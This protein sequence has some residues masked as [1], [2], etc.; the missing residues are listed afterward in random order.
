M[1]PLLVGT[2]TEVTSLDLG[3]NKISSTV[4]TQ[5]GYMT[6]LTQI[7]MG[8][9]NYTGSLPTEIFSLKNLTSQAKWAANR[10][11]GSLPTEVG[12]T[13]QQSEGMRGWCLIKRATRNPAPTAGQPPPTQHSLTSALLTLTTR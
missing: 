11:D 2:L 3:S 7:D 1:L 4:P 8:D 13:V 6:A 5:L 10:L 9:N 12:T